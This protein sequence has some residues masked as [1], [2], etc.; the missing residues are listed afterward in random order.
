MRKKLVSICRVC[1]LLSAIHLPFSGLYGSFVREAASISFNGIFLFIGI[2]IIIGNDKSY[3][4][5]SYWNG[6]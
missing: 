6:Y 5:S 2:V 1:A 3:A 4:G